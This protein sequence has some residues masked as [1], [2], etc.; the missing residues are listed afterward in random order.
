MAKRGLELLFI[1]I[2][3]ALLALLGRPN[4]PPLADS[5]TGLMDIMLGLT[6]S[7][8]KVPE[9]RLTV[10]GVNLGLTQDEVHSRIEEHLGA[11]VPT[12]VMERTQRFDS[13][14]L[15]VTV[16]YD[17]EH[18]VVW[19]TGPSLELNGEALLDRDVDPDQITEVLGPPDS[20][21]LNGV[22]RCEGAYGGYWYADLQATIAFR[23]DGHNQVTLGPR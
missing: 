18:R 7:P 2:L 23:W 8:V 21:G 10:A 19:V 5:D 22:S 15:S 3:I 13:G 12:P 14:D 20:I 11:T 16:R 9:F 1:L 6:D 4:T 17:S